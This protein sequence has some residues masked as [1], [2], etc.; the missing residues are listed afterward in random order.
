[1]RIGDPLRHILRGK[2][3]RLCPQS[4]RLSAD[5]NCIRSKIDRSL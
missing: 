4:K 5:I 1:M 3:L 2:I